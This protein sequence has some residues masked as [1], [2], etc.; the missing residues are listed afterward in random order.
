MAISGSSVA[1]FGNG[2][3][4]QHAQDRP[5]RRFSSKKNDLSAKFSMRFWPG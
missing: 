1:A 3:E 2:N 4:K 5:A